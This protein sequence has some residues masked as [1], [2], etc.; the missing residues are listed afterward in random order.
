MKSST[1][2][3][4]SIDGFLSA[5]WSRRQGIVVPTPSSIGLVNNEAVEIEGAVLY[6]D[7]AGSSKL[8]QDY[9]DYFVAE[10]YKS[11]LFAAAEVIKNNNGEI[12][13]FDG[14]R[15][16][17]VFVGDVKCSNAAKTALQIFG[18]VRKVNEHIA[19]AYPSTSY[20][21]N[22]GVGLDCSKLFVVRTGVRGDNDLAWIG[23]ASNVAAKLSNLR[24]F[25]GRSF[26]TRRMFDR[27]AD[28]SK[29]SIVN[30]NKEC[31]WS[32][33]SEMVLGH[34]VYQSTWYWDF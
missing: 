30:G 8:T 27:I 23:D 15:V 25:P 19:K 31:M 33:T 28:Y 13:A 12:T 24:G 20:R 29:Y 1:E 2:I 4:N 6:A 32:A 10:I 9:K 14:D 17:A 18:M 22:Y 26:M 16:M 21:I 7:L 34:Q 11:F 3:L 5:K